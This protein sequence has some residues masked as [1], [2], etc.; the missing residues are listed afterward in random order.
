MTDI[1]KLLRE[2]VALDDFPESLIEGHEDAMLDAATEIDILSDEIETMCEDLRAV[3]EILA[4]QI[5]S[6]EVIDRLYQRIQ[7]RYLND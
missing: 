2:R 3:A 4:T 1:A 5:Q 7:K 6:Q